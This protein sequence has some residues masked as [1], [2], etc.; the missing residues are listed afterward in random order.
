MSMLLWF[1][2]LVIALFIV[3]PIAP[4]VAMLMVFALVICW[5]S[6]PAASRK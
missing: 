2:C 4:S 6:N 1:F 5:P 3:G